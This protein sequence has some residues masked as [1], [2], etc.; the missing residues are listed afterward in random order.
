MPSIRSSAARRRQE[1]REKRAGV[2]Q[3][4]EQSRA[5]ST[6][7][8][9][10]VGCSTWRYMQYT[11]CQWQPLLDLHV[12]LQLASQAKVDGRAV[13]QRACMSRVGTCT[14]YMRMIIAGGSA[15]EDAGGQYS[16]LCGGEKKLTTK[17]RECSRE[18]EEEGDRKDAQKQKRQSMPTRGL[19]GTIY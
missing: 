16:A 19:V 12:R 11:G 5:K 6:A 9:P 1:A 17:R 13:L 3:L 2:R 14:R 8:P 18:R 4:V 10:I 7:R 15:E